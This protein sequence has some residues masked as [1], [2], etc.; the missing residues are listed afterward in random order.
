MDEDKRRSLLEV[1][2]HAF[3]QAMNGNQARVFNRGSIR[4]DHFPSNAYANWVQWKI[5]FVAVAEANQWTDSQSINALPICLN[6]PALEKF[7]FTPQEL[8]AQVANQP[9]LT[10][11]DFLCTWIQSLELY[12][13]TELDR[14][15]SGLLFRRIMRLFGSLQVESEAWVH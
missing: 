4:H 12:V 15:N 9:A 13:T 10:F 3:G 2:R 1:A 5:H 14:T 11:E 8:K 7:V 6:G